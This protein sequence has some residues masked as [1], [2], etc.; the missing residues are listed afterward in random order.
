LLPRSAGNSC[1]STATNG[2][3]ALSTAAG[4]HPSPFAQLVISANVHAA[5]HSSAEPVSS[6]VVHAAP[7][8]Q[9][10][11]QSPSQ[12]SGACTTPSP[13]VGPPSG[14]P[15]SSSACPESKP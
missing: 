9:L 6:S 3:C 5:V 14:A 4:Q 13:Q 15:P 12:I 1:C 2:P 11:G 10:V 8:S 7:S